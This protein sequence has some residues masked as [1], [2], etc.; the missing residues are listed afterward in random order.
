MY[1]DSITRFRRKVEVEKKVSAEYDDIIELSLSKFDVLV[2]NATKAIPVAFINQ[3][4][5]AG[6]ETIIY[7]YARDK[8]SLGDYIKALNRTYLVY[9]EFKNVKREEYISAFYLAECNV[10]FEYKGSLILAPF[11]GPLRQKTSEEYDLSQ[12][13]G[14]LSYNEAFIMLPS[15]G[16]NSVNIKVNEPLNIDGQGWRTTFIDKS[17]NKG[18]AYVR[19]EEFL[20][21]DTSKTSVNEVPEAEPLMLM[22][23]FSEPVKEILAGITQTFATESGYFKSDKTVNILERRGSSIKFIVPFGIEEINIEIKRDGEIISEYYKV[24]G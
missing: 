16:V 14:V 10:N 11:R 23:T 6:N 1:D 3:D 24:R 8:V 15:L 2:N 13:L 18:I 19:L 21:T 7:T 9:K 20:L 22:K 4:K 17:T 5:E 12:D